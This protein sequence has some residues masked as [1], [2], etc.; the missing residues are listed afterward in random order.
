MT[1]GAGL[2]LVAGL[3]AGRTTREIIDDTVDRTTRTLRWLGV[4]EK[5]RNA[6]PGGY[7][8]GARLE[9]VPSVPTRRMSDRARGKQRSDE[10]SGHLDYESFDAPPTSTI[11]TSPRLSPLLQRFKREAT[12]YSGARGEGSAYVDYSRQGGGAAFAEENEGSSWRR[13]EVDF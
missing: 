13:R 2:G 5:K 10:F 11:R 7:G 9:K 4:L 1:F 12:A 3:V 6:G 8:E